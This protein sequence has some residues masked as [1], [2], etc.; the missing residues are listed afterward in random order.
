ML[1]STYRELRKACG[2]YCAELLEALK[3]PFTRCRIMEDMDRF[4][5]SGRSNIGGFHEMYKS[6]KG[7]QA[8]AW[9]FTGDGMYLWEG[10]YEPQR[11]TM[12]PTIAERTGRAPLEVIYDCLLDEEGPHSGVLWRPLLGYSGNNDAVV[13][14]FEC[15]SLIPGFDDAGAHN[16]L[17]TD[18]TCTTSNVS[19]Y[20][21]QRTR[22]PTVPL[23]RVVKTQTS[24]AA[25]IFG[26]TDRGVI[27]PG[28]RAD[29]NIIDLT[30]LDVKAPYWANDLPTNAGRWLQYAEGYRAT[31]LRGVATFRDDQHTGEL[32][33]RLVRN[34]LGL[35]LA[36]DRSSSVR[37][38]TLVEDQ[39]NV[40][41]AQYA[42]DLSRSGGASAV[43]RVLREDEK[44]PSR[45]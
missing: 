17:L 2:G 33:G 12:I 31:F 30:R 5:P 28:K 42:V 21:R 39:Q 36:V 15:D 8:A 14:A 40:D 16:T 37:A 25:G 11:E 32:P 1:S 20:G 4:K 44:I 10:T 41:L 24:D 7:V 35:G 26:L 29:I 3:D 6:D 34:P 13:R 18:A 19:Y 45:L 27:M 9:M 38:S 22:G 23:E 43:A